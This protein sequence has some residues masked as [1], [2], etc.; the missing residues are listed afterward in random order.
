MHKMG[1]T[2]KL[3]CIDRLHITEFPLTLIQCVTVSTSNF[4]W[5]KNYIKVTLN[6]SFS[7]PIKV[8]AKGLF[9]STRLYTLATHNKRPA[10][11][12]TPLEMEVK[13]DAVQITVCV[14]VP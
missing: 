2:A 9:K 1:L 7:I 8:K 3:A 6:I 10:V 13:Q 12:L 4:G 5:K 11:L 14:E